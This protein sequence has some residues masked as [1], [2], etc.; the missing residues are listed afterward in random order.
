MQ[1][2]VV[3]RTQLGDFANN[4]MGMVIRM[5]AEVFVAAVAGVQ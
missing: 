3:V 1:I 2:M 4:A 5:L